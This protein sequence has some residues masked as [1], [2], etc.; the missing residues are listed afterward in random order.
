LQGAEVKAVGL[1]TGPHLPE[2]GLVAFPEHSPSE[3]LSV[4][5]KLKQLL[6]PVVM[7]NDANLFAFGE[8]W[9][10]AWEGY[11]HMLGMTLGTG[12]GAV[13]S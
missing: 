7:E 8:N 3:R 6:W 5:P 1:D 10:G 11:E 2:A 4:G 9:L 13:S 12:V